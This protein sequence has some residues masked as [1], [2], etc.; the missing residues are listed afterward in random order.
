MKK[1][2][3]LL[4]MPTF[5]LTRA[6]AQEFKM[7]GR[8][9]SFKPIEKIY[10]TY[11]N[12]EGSIFDSIQ[13]KNGVFQI[14]GKLAEPVIAFMSIKYVLN[15]GETA[16]DDFLQFYLE[17]AKINLTATSSL[18][19]AKIT[20]SKGQPDFERIK[21]KEKEYNQSL[22]KAQNNYAAARR[23]GDKNEMEKLEADMDQIKQAYAEN[24]YADFLKKN[25]QTPIGLYL[26][27]M[28]RS[29][30][31]D[32]DKTE[33][34][35]KKLPANLQ[36]YPSGVALKDRIK[37]DQNTS[38][39]R[40]A[41]DFT[42]NDTSGNPVSLSSFK[43]KYVLVDF[44]ASWC[45]PCR[46]ENPNLVKAYNKYKDKN[47]TILGVSLDAPEGKG[48]WI[49]A[50]HDDGLTWN[51]VSDLKFWKNEVAVQYGINSVPQNLLID[52]QGKIV[53]KNLRG[54]ALEEKLTELI[55]L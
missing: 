53:A 42:Q 18:K 50:I 48:R 25:P 10:F 44:W 41:M 30:R 27:S 38:I 36:Q 26:V 16:T 12:G 11:N 34:L 5:I 19:N 6:S 20:G 37:V 35:F 2:A 40:Y 52:P 28:Y 22:E 3:L 31:H 1:L 21:K 43:G 14:K 4:M 45:K 46:A 32:P 29:F 17:P 24:V 55:K 15:A 51:H 39:G 33:A 13:V 7:D 9:N 47:F 49:K 8:L 54:E 23:A